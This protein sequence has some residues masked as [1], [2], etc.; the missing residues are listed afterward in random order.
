MA[1]MKDIVSK[2]ITYRTA[3]ETF[4]IT[5][6]VYYDMN[7]SYRRKPYN[8][9]M[10]TFTYTNTSQQITSEIPYYISG[11]NTNG[12][13]CNLLLPFI[14][15]ND[16]T[17]PYPGMPQIEKFCPVAV[18]GNFRGHGALY[19]YSIAKNLKLY[20]INKQIL[21]DIQNHKYTQFLNNKLENDGAD[22]LSVL[23]RI[24]NLLDFIIAI[25]FS[26][27]ADPE[28]I[29]LTDDKKI[30]EVIP[31]IPDIEKSEELKKLDN[32]FRGLLN[33]KLS[34]YYENLKLILEIEQKKISVEKK[35][36][37]ELNDE[38]QICEDIH[39]H[40]KIKDISIN[41]KINVSTYIIISQKIYESIKSKIEEQQYIFLKDI[42]ND[43]FNEIYSDST[44]SLT[45]Q[46]IGMEGKCTPDGSKPNIEELIKK[47]D[48]NLY[49]N[50]INSF[51]FMLNG[52]KN[53]YNMFMECYNSNITSEATSICSKLYTD[54]LKQFDYVKQEFMMNLNYNNDKTAKYPKYYTELQILKKV[55]EQ[56]DQISTK[57]I[58][59]IIN[60]EILKNPSG[61]TIKNITNHFEVSKNYIE[62]HMGIL[63]E[64]IENI[65][66][67]LHEINAGPPSGPP[68]GQRTGEPYPKSRRLLQKYQQKYKQKYL[69]YKQKYIQLKNINNIK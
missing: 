68:S 46:I 42:L 53:N 61:I 51:Y 4:E 60:D 52:I 62:T 63:I 10:M 39:E 22:L 11:G 55:K 19:K 66:R 2:K 20:T 48:N 6:K 26:K 30:E 3:T 47:K 1:A 56:I 32:Q 69:K 49:V 28:F 34:E 33:I 38:L 37:Q 8:V 64:Y 35:S 15:I 44:E 58:F 21:R 17:G 12:Y 40:P 18:S 24:E 43:K 5:P 54:L 23:P 16:L 25:C 14:C 9:I 65:S 27:I 57:Q 31:K 7:L 41:A 13:N 50:F 36:I 67:K 29:T 59:D 45:E